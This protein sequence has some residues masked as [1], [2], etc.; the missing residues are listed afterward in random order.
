MFDDLLSELNKNKSAKLILKFSENP[1]NLKKWVIHD[2]FDNQTSVLLQNLNL[3]TEI[4]YL[5][6]FQA[7]WD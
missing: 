7:V 3:G 4:S 6:F 5:L 1:V 2:E